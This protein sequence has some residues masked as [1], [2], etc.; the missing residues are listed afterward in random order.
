VA[1]YYTLSIPLHRKGNSF[2]ADG[3]SSARVK[4]NGFPPWHSTPL[5]HMKLF[6]SH[7]Q[8][9]SSRISSTAF[10]TEQSSEV[11]PVLPEVRG[12]VAKCILV[13]AL[14]AYQ[15]LEQSPDALQLLHPSVRNVLHR[16]VRH[17]GQDS[18]SAQC[19]CL[20]VLHFCTKL[21]SPGSF[22]TQPPQRSTPNN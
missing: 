14:S 6:T 9:Y 12:K 22:A 20:M 13:L 19:V 2:A 16:I 7:L 17:C 15:H 11:L 18:Q 1:I 4:P 8:Y 21:S 3:S 10:K 5:F